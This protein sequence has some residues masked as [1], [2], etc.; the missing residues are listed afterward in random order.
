MQE[1]LEKLEKIEAE[2]GDASPGQ[3]WRK[4]G[5]WI[6]IGLLLAALA[7]AG[8]WGWWSL[9]PSNEP[10]PPVELLPQSA[11][12][13]LPAAPETPEITAP[14]EPVITETVANA[15]AQTTTRLADL[16]TELG[17]LEE[18]V[19]APSNA[20]DA[21]AVT[22]LD[23]AVR[24]ISNSL[25]TISAAMTAM[26]LRLSTLEAVQAAQPLG[27]E[28]KRISYAL[29]LREMERALGGSGPYAVELDTLSKLLDASE[30]DPAIAQLRTYA[31]TGVQT[32]AAL[33]ARFDPTAAAIVRAD[34]ASGVAPGWAGRTYAFV[35]SLVMIRPL[36]ERDGADA[37]SRVARAQLRLE[38]GDLD[39]AVRELDALDGPAAE[40][41]A[42]WLND[43]RA[44]LAAEQALA[45]LT[46]TLTQKLNEA[47]GP[48][49]AAPPPAASAPLTDNAGE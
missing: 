41:A 27:G 44:R 16:E 28:A 35:T 11:A 2:P 26:N 21:S 39:A 48:A 9:R 5:P 46:A 42:A 37:P 47:A 31:D 30:A 19:A 23:D 25:D 29:G 8:V 22:Q 14:V 1:K 15:L 43:A 4:Y 17:R 3:S 18:A 13:P 10:R 33:E 40:A 45:Q 6:A 32:R 36:G 7:L 49:H 12:L 34:A 24:A 20:A 38:E